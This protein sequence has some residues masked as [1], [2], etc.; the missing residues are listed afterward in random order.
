MSDRLDLRP[1]DFDPFSYRNRLR[2]R[3]AYSWE[4]AG[5]ECFLLTAAEAALTIAE[6]QSSSLARAA[7]PHSSA[8]MSTAALIDW[9]EDPREL[10]EESHCAILWAGGLA[11]MACLNSVQDLSLAARY[12]TVHGQ[13]I[14]KLMHASLQH[15]QPRVTV[16]LRIH[17]GM[18]I[19]SLD[20]AAS[21]LA[22]QTYRHF[23]TVLL[24]DGLWE[25]GQMLA[26]RYDLPLICTGQ[27]PDIT[28]CSW[29]HRQ[30]V[31]QCDTEFYKPLDYDDQLLP[32]ISR[33]G[34]CRRWMSKCS[35]Y[36]A[37]C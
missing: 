15:D 33:A 31:E 11:S 21:S 30:A 9:N 26:A 14:A 7:W 6:F 19:E 10:A 25:Y 3:L 17:K 22:M 27:E 24:V 13:M 18:P 34:R 20:E 1:L 5:S 28:H 29:L 12:R 8:R 4:T 35:T 2:R 32:E 23:K 36:M 37:A 16:G